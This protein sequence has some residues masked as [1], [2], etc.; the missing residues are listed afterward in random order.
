M[1]EYA[2]F[3]YE[4]NCLLGSAYQVDDARAFIEKNK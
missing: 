1:K 4:K 2:D 3:I